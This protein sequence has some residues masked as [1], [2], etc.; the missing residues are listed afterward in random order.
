MAENKELNSEFPQK[1][2]WTLDEL[3][4][5]FPQIL[6]TVVKKF[7]EI[8]FDNYMNGNRSM[9]DFEPLMSQVLLLKYLMEGDLPENLQNLLNN[10]VKEEGGD[11]ERM[12]NRFEEL[13]SEGKLK[14]YFGEEA[15]NIIKQQ[16]DK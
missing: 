16:A 2:E 14:T 11:Y 6:E 1:G 15:L 4:Q 5:H 9:P 3:Q 13:S 8:E 12:T 10:G 7:K